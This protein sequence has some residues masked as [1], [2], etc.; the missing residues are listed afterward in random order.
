LALVFYVP[1]AKGR[2]FLYLIELLIG[3]LMLVGG[4]ELLVRGGAQLALA[5]RVPAMVVGLTIV[6]FG[7]ST[8]ELA[9][10]LSAA[11]QASTEM[12]LANVNGSNIA[13][14]LLVLGAA[15]LVRPLCIDRSLLRREI[16]VLVLLQ[17]IVLVACMNGV[18]GPWEGLVFLIVGLGYNGLLLWQTFRRG[19]AGLGDLDEELLDEVGE[20]N[21]SLGRNVAY[22]VV[23]IFILVGGAWLFIEGSISLAEIL[24]FSDRFIGLS[25]VALGTSAP[26][27]V[28]A[29]VSCYRGQVDLAIGNSIGSNILNIAMVLALTAMVSPVHIADVGAW[30]DLGMALA[31]ALLMLIMVAAGGR[32]GR[33]AGLAMLLGYGLFIVLSAN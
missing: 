22:L 12:A 1:L 26:E 31:V 33:P 20:P 16:P 3:L 23:G 29:I 6:A 4:A 2:L 14:V 30:Y 15:A 21:G 25:C 27:L 5:F 8:P 9:T 32:L 13:N 19:R 11:F 18:I 24:G 10:S 17:T 28:T 7:T